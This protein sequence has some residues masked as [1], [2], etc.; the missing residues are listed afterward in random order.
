MPVWPH[1]NLEK[2]REAGYSFQE[3]SKCAAPSC[4][5]IVH[6]FITPKGKW[7]P[8]ETLPDGRMETHFARCV[9]ARKFSRKNKDKVEAR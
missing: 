6:W 3:A 5:T 1:D 7:M 9:E 4:D 8:M 2:L